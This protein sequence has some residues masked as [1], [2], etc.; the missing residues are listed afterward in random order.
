MRKTAQLYD[1]TRAL[2]LAAM[3]L[4]VTSPPLAHAGNDLACT[5]TQGGCSFTSAEEPDG[6]WELAITC[7]GETTFLSGSGG[8]DSYPAGAECESVT[9]VVG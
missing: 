3:M 6:D 4:L 5:W 8:I 1:Y 2:L 9:P 7:G